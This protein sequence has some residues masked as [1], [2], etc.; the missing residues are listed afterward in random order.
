MNILIPDS[1][2][3]EHLKTKAAPKQ[4]AE[5]LSLCS[6]SV[7]RLTKQGNDWLYDV[8]ITT[9]RPD[10]LSLYGIARELAVILPRFGIKA[11]LKSL[12]EAKLDFPLVKKSLPF[13][14]EI[15]DQSLCP[16]FTALIFDQIKIGPSPKVIQE[17][18]NKAGIRALN[19]VVDI[20]NYLMIEL[21]Q[22]MHTFDYDKILEAKM[23][24]RKSI[25]GERLATLDGQERELPVGTIVIE[26]GSGRL[27]DLCG[28]M[29]GANS[30]VDEKTQ[31]VLL[32]V[33][34]YDPVCIRQTCQQLAFR[35]E[36]ASRFEK[37]IEPEGVI[38]AMKKAMAMFRK[39]CRARIASKLI[40]I[41]PQKPK[42]RKIRLTQARLN[43]TMGIELKLT[44][45]KKILEDL[46]FEIKLSGQQLTAT[47]PHWRQTDV[48]LP[49]GLIEEVARIYGYH[50]LPTILPTGQI[51]QE[52][53]PWPFA[54][55][56][57]AKSLLANWGLTEVVNYSLIS[58]EQIS[59]I[60]YQP[61]KYLQ[62]S[63]PL[64]QELVYLRPSLLP[65]MLQAVAVNQAQRE[66]IKLF[67]LANIYLPRG[68]Q[69]L[70]DERMTLMAV[71]TG[72]DF[73]RVKGILEGLL[74]EL[75][76]TKLQFEPE[77]NSHIWHP[78]RSGLIKTR[79][80]RVGLI[81]EIQPSILKK[82]SVKGRVVAFELDFG[83]IS[84]MAT[85]EKSYRPIPKYPAT[86]EDLSFVIKP[87]TL[88]GEMIQLIKA[89]SPFIQTV[90][91]LDAYKQTRTFR[92][93]YQ[94]SQKTLTDKEVE[95]IRQKVIKKIK[96]KFSAKIKG[97]E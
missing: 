97:Q 75:G 68:K 49:E 38:P 33:Q 66:K 22:P 79:G 76:L 80:K 17:R 30:E 84:Q 16:R 15:K 52:T 60:G 90:E 92:I 29:G 73:A 36:A 44:E 69:K 50:R 86:I 43:Q 40:D 8:E 34:T 42:E 70:P 95:K 58:Q 54:W 39:N 12:T 35:T 56:E 91:L 47:V 21:G 74:G 10:C 81:G 67:E 65:S 27:I 53:N 7:E 94:S 48:F 93:T 55:E 46:G 31:R 82:F 20:S 96:E 63:N 6:Q 32:F 19:N 26:D 37:G 88:V 83:E 2:L 77:A 1:W 89:S 51:P 85:K 78:G 5:Y 71:F 24:L 25:K 61:E 13:S 9:N 18:L 23:V 28:I 14:V 57:K 41:Y 87:K 11:R 64:S 62:L 4:V 72:S 3:R 59:Q 45:A